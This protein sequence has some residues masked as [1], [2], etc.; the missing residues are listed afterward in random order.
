[1]NDE[2]YITTA[3]NLLTEQGLKTCRILPKD[4][5]LVSCIGEIGKIGMTADER[6]A[7]NQQINAV[8]CNENF[9]PNFVYYLLAFKKFD[10]QKYASKVTIPILNKG[11]FSKIEIPCPPQP[12]Q[13]KI[14]K[15]LDSIRAEIGQQK[16]IIEKTKELKKSLMKKL[17]SQGT[18]GEKI[19]FSEIAEFRNGINFGREQKGVKGTL[20]LDVFNMYNETIYP[21]LNR[22]Y[23]VDGK[24]NQ[25][26]QLRFGDLL[27]VRSSLK[28]EGVGWVTMFDKFQEP[29]VFCGFIIRARL[30]TNDF[31]PEYLTHLFRSTVYRNQLVHAKGTVGIT[32][33]SQDILANLKINKISILKQKE[34]A[35][36]LE[37][38]D[39]KIE[40]AQKQ[41][42]LYEELFNNSLN[43]LMTREIEVEN[44]NL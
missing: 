12:I 42:K 17:F 2:K 22:L 40:L 6:S 26:Y 43:K 15:V 38:V 3:H 32:N 31:L 4:S 29:I 41:K 19:K 1:L 23:R 37:K 30:N 36:I 27:F 10:I 44:I 20:T 18:R 33:I 14:V 16:E 35:L 39:A 8:I 25:N 21:D 9:E 5:V 13:Q 7:S 28:P 11:N 34:I 24:F